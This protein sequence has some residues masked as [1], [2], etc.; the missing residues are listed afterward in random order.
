M[1]R[2]INNCTYDATLRLDACFSEAFGLTCGYGTAI[3]SGNEIGY[4]YGYAEMET[5]HVGDGCYVGSGQ[6]DAT[7][8]SGVV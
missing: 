1:E 4:G 3:G 2:W 7:G 8:Y 6:S 5:L